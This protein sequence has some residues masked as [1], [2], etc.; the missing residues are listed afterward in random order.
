MW[1]NGCKSELGWKYPVFFQKKKFEIKK[2]TE[3][4]C[5]EKKTNWFSERK[6]IDKI[7]EIKVTK[8]KA[9]K[10]LLALLK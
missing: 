4:I 6:N 5:L 8:Y 3:K 10:I 9:G 1:S 2:I 7:D